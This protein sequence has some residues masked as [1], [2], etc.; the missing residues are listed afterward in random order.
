MILWTQYTE[1]ENASMC[2]ALECEIAPRVIERN[3]L[4]TNGRCRV[5]IFY[6]FYE[7]VIKRKHYLVYSIFRELTL[8]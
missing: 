2:F 1:L 6:F 5:F 7:S 3:T 8:S 4:C